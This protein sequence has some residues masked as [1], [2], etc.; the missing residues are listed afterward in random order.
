MKDWTYD[1]PEELET[2]F[3]DV[4]KRIVKV[5]GVDIETNRYVPEFSLIY[6]NGEWTL[7]YLTTLWNLKR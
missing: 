6:K 1:I 5:N 3:V 2:V 7:D 4:K